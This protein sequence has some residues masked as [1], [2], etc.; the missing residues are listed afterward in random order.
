MLHNKTEWSSCKIIY[1]R[2]VFVEKASD[3]LSDKKP[4]QRKQRL[5]T[6]FYG[7]NDVLDFWIMD[8]RSLYQYKIMWLAIALG[9]SWAKGN[10][11]KLKQYFLRLSF[12]RLARIKFP[13]FRSFKKERRKIGKTKHKKT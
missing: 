11:P 1:E 4:P 13:S 10:G 5:D 8:T 12:K 7:C 9:I 3:T 6:S 2:K